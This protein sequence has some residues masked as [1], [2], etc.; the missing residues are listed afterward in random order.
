M[1]LLKGV[2]MAEGIP[3]RS[4]LKQFVEIFQKP[5]GN[6]QALLRIFVDFVTKLYREPHL[7]EVRCRVMTAFLDELW[8]NVPLRSALLHVRKNSGR[9]FGLNPVGQNQFDECFDRWFA[10]VTADRLIGS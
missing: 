5:T 8:S 10:G 7:P 1:T 6:L 9:S 3:W 2:E 4:P